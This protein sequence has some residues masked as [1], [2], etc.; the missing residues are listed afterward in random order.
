MR[1]K[2]VILPAAVAAGNWVSVDSRQS[3]FNVGVSFDVSTSASLTFKLQ[4]AWYDPISDRVNTQ[5]ITRSTTTVTAVF[6]QPHG[7]KVGDSVTVFGAGAGIDG[8]YDV[9]TTADNKTITYTV[10]N[11]G[12]TAPT[13]TVT[14]CKFHVQDDATITAKTSSIYGSVSVPCSYI[15]GNVTVWVSGN[16]A[17]TVS[18]GLSGLS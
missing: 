14:I 10:A 7:L 5:N 6:P 13:G 3:N 1:T 15:R 2:T 11:S 9:A 18:Q 12:V 17:M 16:V 8:T 4:E